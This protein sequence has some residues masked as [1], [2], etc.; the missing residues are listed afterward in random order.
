MTELAHIVEKLKISTHNAAKVEVVIDFHQFVKFVLVQDDK[1]VERRTH[2]ACT[3]QTVNNVLLVLF[4][5]KQNAKYLHLTCQHRT[6][7][8]VMRQCNCYG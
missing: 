7:Q 5:H 3:V 8:K 4:Q 6:E 1:L 2:F